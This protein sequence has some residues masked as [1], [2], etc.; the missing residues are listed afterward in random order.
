[1]TNF[2]QT[3]G[4]G[5]SAGFT[6]DT[7]LTAASGTE[8]A[9][10]I[11]PTVNQS[12]TAG[13]SIVKINPTSTAT[14]S[15]TK[16]LLNAAVGGVNVANLYA[17]SPGSTGSILTLYDV[18]GGTQKMAFGTSSGYSAIFAGTV[19]A[20][21]YRWSTNDFDII[22]NT[23]AGGSHYFSSGAGGALL[24]IN[25]SGSIATYRT[26]ATAGWGVPAIYAAG[27]STAQTAAVTSVAT[28]TNT[29]ADGSYEV[30]ANVLVTTATSHA[31][32]VTCSYTDEG[33]TA[34]TATMSFS[35]LAGGAMTTS[36][37]N[38]NGAVPYMG[39]PL[40]IRSKASTAITIATT[41]T[42]TTVTYNVEG[43][44]KRLS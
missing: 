23:A 33:N 7:N 35:L 30:S 22:Y 24:T 12:G 16:A 36:V 6:V 4:G 3:G 13:Y 26:A 28:Y 20:F 1:M 21:A 9:L 38:A 14:G 19:S 41:G 42:F 40:T 34:R 32:T 29:A 37:A 39:I 2:A 27:R 31:F 18:S 17:T 5:G 44:I 10:D 8:T 11:N 25:S 43:F 15:G